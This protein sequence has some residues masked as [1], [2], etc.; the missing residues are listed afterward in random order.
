MYAILLF[1]HLSMSTTDLLFLS[2]SFP[3]LLSCVKPFSFGW[4]NHSV[5]GK[6]IA[7]QVQNQSHRP[8]EMSVSN[9]LWWCVW[10]AKFSS[11]NQYHNTEKGRR[12]KSRYSLTWNIICQH[13]LLTYIRA[14]FL[15]FQMKRGIIWN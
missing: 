12:K 15:L 7:A 9:V 13:I 3:F 4:D 8:L 6:K 11:A 5:C 14:A 10:K 1:S 2:L